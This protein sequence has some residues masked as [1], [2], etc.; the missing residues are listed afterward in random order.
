VNKMHIFAILA[1]RKSLA[2]S[3]GDAAVS[4]VTAA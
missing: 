1:G 4:N 2:V 3:A